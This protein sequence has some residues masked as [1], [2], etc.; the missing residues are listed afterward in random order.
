MI[1]QNEKILRFLQSGGR[2][3]SLMSYELWGCTR[4]ASRIHDLK[5]AGHLIKSE[6][7]TVKNR[8]GQGNITVSE[9]RLEKV[10][11]QK[12]IF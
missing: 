10:G 3:T 12:L 9:Y 4:L 2:I 7:I 11:Q 1:S 5:T 6:T 8:Y